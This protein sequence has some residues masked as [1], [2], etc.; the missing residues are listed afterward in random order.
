MSLPKL[1]LTSRGLLEV[2]IDEHKE[3][4]SVKKRLLFDQARLIVLRTG[5]LQQDFSKKEVRINDISL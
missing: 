3:N 5:V 1:A 4:I 2:G